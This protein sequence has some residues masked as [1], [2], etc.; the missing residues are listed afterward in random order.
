MGK[1]CQN[2]LFSILILL[3]MRLY[4]ISFHSNSNH[5]FK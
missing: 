4:V 5:S 1:I 2:H 3:F